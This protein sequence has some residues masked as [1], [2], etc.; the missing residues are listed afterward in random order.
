VIR[1]FWIFVDYE[2]KLILNL[3]IYDLLGFLSFDVMN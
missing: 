1:W 2:L 3:L